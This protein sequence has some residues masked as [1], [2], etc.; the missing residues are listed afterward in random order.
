[1]SN[2][3]Y[4]TITGFAGADPIF[5][6]NETSSDVTQ[7]SVGV[8]P[9]FW[10]REKQEYRDGATT[11][12]EVR[13][14]GVLGK[15]MADSCRRGTPLLV[16]GRLTTREWTASEDEKS[17]PRTRLVIVADSV[18]V[19]LSLGTASYAKVRRGE[20]DLGSLNSIVGLRAGET[21]PEDSQFAVGQEEG[22]PAEAEQHDGAPAADM[23]EIKEPQEV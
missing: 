11:W 5:F 20:E 14:R 17:T 9:S 13:A 7:V 6:K 3:T 22:A 16:R 23:W 18:G 21:G 12:Y 15:N 2:E 8:T 10:D 19:E 4:V 1:M